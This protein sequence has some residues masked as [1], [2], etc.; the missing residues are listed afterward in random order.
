[1]KPVW[2]VVLIAILIGWRGLLSSQE[3]SNYVHGPEVNLTNHPSSQNIRYGF[4]SSSNVRSLLV[5]SQ[6]NFY[7]VWDHI[8]DGDWD[9]SFC[10]YTETGWQLPVNVSNNSSDSRAGSMALRPPYS[11][12]QEQVWVAWTDFNPFSLFPNHRL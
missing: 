10:R 1:M 5:D 7:V 12:D 11:P 3:S 2:I 6:N 4:T 9:I 8:R